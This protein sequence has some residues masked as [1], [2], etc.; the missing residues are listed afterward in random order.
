MTNDTSNLYIALLSIHGLIRGTN[1]E[2]GRDADTGGQILYVLELAQALAKQP[3]VA[4]VDLITLRVV[5]DTVAED[6]AEPIETLSD[7]LRIVRINTD[8]DEYIA[9]EQLWDHLDGFADNVARFF[10]ENNSLPDIIHSHYAD[11]GYVGAHLSNLLGVPLIHT[12]HSLGRVKRHRLLA[13]GL[14]HD[15]IEKRYNMARRIEAEELVLSTAERVITSTHQEIEEQYELYDFYQPEQMRVVPPGTDLT[16]FTPATGDELNTPLFGDITRHLKEPD[17]PIIL[18]LSRPDK[19]KNIVMLVEAYG[20]SVELQDLANLVIVAGN[21]DDIDEL[22]DG[23]QEVF[24]EL[25]VA[26]DRYDIYSK[27][28]LPKHH[29]RDQVPLFYA[30]AAA[31]GGVFVNPA[32]T[33]PF[34]LTLIEAAASGLPIV[35]TE[36]GGPRD[37]IGNCKNGFLID[38]L[39]P[40]SIT[41]ALLKL[42][43]DKKLWQ[44]CVEQGLQ[45]VRE[46]YTWDGHAQRYLQLIRPIV[47]RSE[48]LIR[49]PVQRRPEVHRDRAIVSDLDQNL[50]GDTEALPQLSRVLRQHRK[51]AKFAIATGRRLDVALKLMKKHKIP[52]PDILITSGGTEIYYAPKL[53]VDVAWSKHIDYHW[54]PHKIRKLLE[55]FPGL[56]KQPRS[57]QSRFKLSYY[58]DPDIADI[59]AIKSLLHSEEQAVNVQMAFGQFLDILPIRASKGLALRYVADRW[60]I[61][62]KRIFVA[63]GSGADEDMIRGNTLAAVV[64]NRHHE[65]LSQLV[66]V[67]RIYFSKKP[68]AEGILEALG[69]YDFFD[70]CK[71]PKETDQSND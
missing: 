56:K 8:P 9:K 66:D 33:E 34:G 71:D 39:E 2:L 47:E 7:N 4:Q 49:E 38:A 52:E 46:H 57:H 3:G 60:Q 15:E 18:A 20:Q 43:S 63:G 68:F 58:I 37:I 59:E 11:G 67:E 64:A 53:A 27:V 69:Y 61:P 23:A 50:L 51:I 16:R 62:L 21:R 29:Q 48:Q 14:S 32:L 24:H 10:R 19:R 22:D 12:G 26:I 55:G 1:L 31:S 65:E 70:T 35:A 36:D 41:D 44:R 25:L 28:A 54:T 30:I 45:G 5:D 17:K 6:Y 42:L 13:S 40:Q